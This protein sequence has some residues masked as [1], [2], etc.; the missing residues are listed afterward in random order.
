MSLDA[1][2]K[3]TPA[4]IEGAPWP[5]GYEAYLTYDS[6]ATPARG[7]REAKAKRYSAC[8]TFPNDQPT[9][10]YVGAAAWVGLT[11]S[12]EVG[13]G[14]APFAIAS[15]EAMGLKGALEAK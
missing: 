7:G 2:K 12:S 5:A 8:M 1:N 4:A 15:I 14:A 10:V 11:P 9:T 13:E 6:L 3:P